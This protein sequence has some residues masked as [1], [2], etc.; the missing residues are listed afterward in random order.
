MDLVQETELLSN[1]PMFAKL[2]PSRLKLLAFTS[3][4]LNYRDGEV[5]FRSG[6]AADC[7]YVIVAGKVDI[8]TELEG[9]E[10][11]SSSLGP[12]QLF[13]ELALLNGAPRSATLRASGPLQVLR[14]SADMFF[15]LL[16]GNADMA[17]DVLRQLADKLVRSHR[18]VE[19]LQAELQRRPG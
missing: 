14:I 7:A 16:R 5:L 6:D 3:E 18:H 11:V 12:Q 8:V 2:E 13:G 1:V 9:G 10:I 19:A 17:M 15:D 4:M